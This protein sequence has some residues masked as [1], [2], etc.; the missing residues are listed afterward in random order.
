MKTLTA[1]PRLLN[2]VQVEMAGGV[3]RCL[4][5]SFQGPV[6][7]WLCSMWSLHYNLTISEAELEALHGTVRRLLDQMASPEAWEASVLGR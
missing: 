6:P 7:R 3:G 4:S 2:G 5:S 1:C